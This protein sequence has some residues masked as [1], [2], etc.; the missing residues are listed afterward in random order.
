MGW[1]KHRDDME[2]GRFIPPFAL[3]LVLT[4]FCL[5]VGFF[6][7]GAGHGSYFF[8]K[9][10]FPFTMISTVFY[11]EITLTF[12]VLGLIQ[13]PMYGVFLG[14]MNRFG[15]KRSAIVALS[16]L[17]LS[18]TAACFLLIGENFS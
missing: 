6:S 8:A 12:L 16:I 13:F 18:A 7:A 15:L 11:D 14:A 4:P 5:L 17:H 1:A 9:V 3:M 2:M 10:L